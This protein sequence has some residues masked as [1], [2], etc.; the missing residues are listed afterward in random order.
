VPEIDTSRQMTE[1][2]VKR[3]GRQPLEYTYAD[4]VKQVRVD[5]KTIRNV[6]DEYVIGLE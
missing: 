1:R 4:V 3:V 5:K 6:F 2:L